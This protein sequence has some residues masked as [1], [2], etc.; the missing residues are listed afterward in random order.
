LVKRSPRRDQAFL[1]PETWSNLAKSWPNIGVRGEAEPSE[2]CA[3]ELDF[4]G[5]RA[6]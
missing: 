5:G 2:R 4:Y 1:G 3:P 6:L